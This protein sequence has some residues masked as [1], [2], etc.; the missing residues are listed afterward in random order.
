[1]ACM[2]VQAI[3]TVNSQSNGKGQIPNPHGA[4]TPEGISVK[5]GNLSH[6]AVS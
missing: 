4:I 5:L 3:A 6:V 1:M 2:V